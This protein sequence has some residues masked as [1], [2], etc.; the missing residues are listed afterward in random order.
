MQS[1]LQFKLFTLQYMLS[2]IQY[3]LY[4]IHHEHYNKQ[5]QQSAIH[6]KI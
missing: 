2:T 3:T 4:P 1:T 5:N 6:N